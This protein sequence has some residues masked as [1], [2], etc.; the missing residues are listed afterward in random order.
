MAYRTGVVLA[1]ALVGGLGLS[2]CGSTTESP[3]PSAE[4]VASTDP[5]PASSEE[6]LS[7]TADQSG[8]GESAEIPEAAVNNLTVRVKLLAPGNDPS[9]L[10]PFCEGAGLAATEKVQI[11]IEDQSGEQLAGT[12]ATS[13]KLAFGED[14]TTDEYPWLCTL[15]SK[16]SDI[17]ADK[18]FYAV[19]F[20]VDAKAF[21][22]AIEDAQDIVRSRQELEDAALVNGEWII[23]ESFSIG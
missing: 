3:A 6:Q 15:T 23:E 1:A 10:S 11:L 18:D 17:P 13:G 5:S 16:F 8:D 14:G 12:Y 9:L 20:S 19:K 7:G 21:D 2:G 22:T 4:A